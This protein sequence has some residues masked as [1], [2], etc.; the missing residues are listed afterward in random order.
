MKISWTV[1]DKTTG[2]FWPKSTEIHDEQIRLCGNPEAAM[3]LIHEA[4]E[5]VFEYEITWDSDRDA[6]EAEA[7]ELLSSKQAI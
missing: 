4:V 6:V 1:L 2:K 3:N 5:S 7:R